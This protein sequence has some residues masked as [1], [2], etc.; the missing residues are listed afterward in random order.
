MNPLKV[1]SST[2]TLM[3]DDSGLSPSRCH[4]HHKPYAAS[5]ASDAKLT[6]NEPLLTNSDKT[7][8]S[9]SSPDDGAQKKRAN[10]PTLGIIFYIVFGVLQTMSVVTNKAAFNMN[11]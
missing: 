11:P 5:K 7:S 8:T 3:S 1:V 10:N 6:Q 2:N 9:E 4:D